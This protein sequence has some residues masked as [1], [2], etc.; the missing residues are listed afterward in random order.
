M[1]KG[2]LNHGADIIY[3]III[4]A[5]TLLLLSLYEGDSSVLQSLTLTETYEDTTLLTVT[6]LHATLKE[7]YAADYLTGK[8]TYGDLLFLAMEDKEHRDVYLDVFD[9]ELMRHFSGYGGRVLGGYRLTLPDTTVKHS[10]NLGPEAPT[11]T[12]P[13][14][15]GET[16]AL[17]IVFDA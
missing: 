12:V 17:Q 7:P 11:Y 4:V 16:I 14:K 5:I 3:G 6:F 1:R 8:E 9:Q 13:Y 2:A 15:D 10:G